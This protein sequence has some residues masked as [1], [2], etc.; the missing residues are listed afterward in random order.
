MTPDRMTPD[1]MRAKAREIREDAAKLLLPQPGPSAQC[2][3]HFAVVEVGLAACA[4]VCERLDHVSTLLQC[5]IWYPPGRA[6][7]CGFHKEI[8]E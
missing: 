8:D 1:E 7:S 3:T 5:S 4:E 2:A 6:C